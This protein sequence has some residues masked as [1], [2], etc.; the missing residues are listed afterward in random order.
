MRWTEVDGFVRRNH[1]K[2]SLINTFWNGRKS[3]D[4]KINKTKNRI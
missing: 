4:S 3:I 2:Y 1:Q